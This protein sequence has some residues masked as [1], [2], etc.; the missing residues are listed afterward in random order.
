MT[1]QEHELYNKEVADLKA[2]M[3][4]K[5]FTSLWADGRSMTMDEAIR[6]AL[7]ET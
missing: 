7:E 5:E 2:N 6:F 1:P 3:G 4:E